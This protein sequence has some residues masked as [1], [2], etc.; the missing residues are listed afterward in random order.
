MLKVRTW[1]DYSGLGSDQS[2]KFWILT[3]QLNK[4]SIEPIE[5]ST[6][7]SPYLQKN[8]LLYISVGVCNVQYVLK[9]QEGRDVISSVDGKC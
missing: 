8:S 9:M 7:F 2:R 1:T 5:L 3:G 4:S 6:L